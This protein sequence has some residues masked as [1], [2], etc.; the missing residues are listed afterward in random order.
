MGVDSQ[1]SVSYLPHPTLDLGQ[2]IDDHRDIPFRDLKGW[3]A[4]QKYSPGKTSSILTL[5]VQRFRIIQF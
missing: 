4:G 5:G 1:R 2:V 3:E